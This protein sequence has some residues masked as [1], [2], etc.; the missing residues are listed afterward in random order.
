VSRKNFWSAAVDQFD[1]LALS[2]AIAAS[3]LRGM[4]VARRASG[5]R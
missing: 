1:L 3:S 4:S 2:G 5:Q